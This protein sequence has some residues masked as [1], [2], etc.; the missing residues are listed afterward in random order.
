M[1][2][3]KKWEWEP[4]ARRKLGREI[5]RRRQQR[6]WTLKELAAAAGGISLKQVSNVES[7]ANWPSMPAYIAI[8]KALGMPTPPLLS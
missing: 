6:Q 8:C 5:W 7:G 4:D 3:S 2:M 1:P